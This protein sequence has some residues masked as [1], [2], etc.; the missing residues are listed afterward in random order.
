MTATE[1]DMAPPLHSQLWRHRPAW[2]EAHIL[3]V[4]GGG[5][6]LDRGLGWPGQIVASLWTAGVF[7]WLYSRGG[8]L[9]RQVLVACMLI[10]GL[11]E[12]VLSLAWGLYDYQFHNIPAFVPPGH[13]LLM[14]LGV[15]TVA[16]I[17][18]WA[19]RAVPFLAAPLA[20]A[21]L[22]QG[23]DQAGIALFLLLVLCMVFSRGRPLYAVMFVLA[24]CMELYGTWLGNW[25]WRPLVPGLHLT[26]SNPPSQAGAFY[27]VLDLLVL[28]A[29]RLL[30]GRRK[31]QDAIAS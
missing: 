26:T 8:L 20:L 25:A 27:C 21:G 16:R 10:A 4:I 23:W 30:A 2:A 18:R 29:L 7:L 6:A 5:L 13:A 31:A 28:G 19:W 11:G 17:P 24:L 1:G 15:L 9:E 14:T 3:A 22:W 12:G